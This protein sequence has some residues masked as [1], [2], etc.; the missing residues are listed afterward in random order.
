MIYT[1]YSYK[2]GVG[3]SMALANIAKYLYDRG[4]R[5]VMIDWDLEA[6]GLENFFCASEEQL[7]DV[8][9]QLGLIDMLEHYK[10]QFAQ[11]RSTPGV[12][13]STVMAQLKPQLLSVRSLLYPIH[14]PDPSAERSSAALW[15]LPAGWRATKSSGKSSRVDDR[16]AK[17]ASAVQSFDW[18]DFYTSFEGNAYFEWFREQLLP[19][20]PGGDSSAIPDRLGV[21]AVLIDSRTGVTEMG[22]ICTRQLADVVVCFC[23]PN[24]QNLEGVASMA[25]TFARDEIT[26]GRGRDLEVL[27]VPSRVDEQGA[28]T[29]EGAFHQRFNA[30]LKPPPTFQ[31]NGLDMYSLLLPYIAKYS[32]SEKLAV[33]VEASKLEKAYRRLAEHLVLFSEPDSM[34]R[35]WF[36][37][38]LQTMTRVTSPRVFLWS[39]EEDTTAAAAFAGQLA[40]I[41][42]A[43]LLDEAQSTLVWL[44]PASLNSPA[45]RR[46]VRLARQKG[47]CVYGVAPRPLAEP[48]LPRVLRKVRVFDLPAGMAGLRTELAKPCQAARV[49]SMAPVLPDF[50]DRPAELLLL[51]SAFLTPALDPVAASL[52]LSGAAGSGK[53]R[54][55]MRLCQ[56]EDIVDAFEDGI[57]WVALGATPDIAAALSGLHSALTGVEPQFSNLSSAVATELAG[58][59]CLVVFDDVWNASHLAAFPLPDTCARLILTRNPS[60]IPDARTINLDAMT[61]EQAQRTLALGLNLPFESPALEGLARR[62][63]R[64][65]LALSLARGLLAQ[66]VTRGQTPEAA[67]EFLSRTL[68]RKG[69]RA[70]GDLA[71]PLESAIRLTFDVAEAELT[72]AERELYADLAIFASDI[73]IPFDAISALWPQDALDT[74]HLLLRLD[75]LALLRV[76][77]Q[78]RI[79]HL[80][81]LL[82]SLLVGELKDVSALHARLLSTWADPRHPPHEF[83]WRWVIYHL[84]QAGRQNEARGLLLDFDWINAKSAATDLPALLADYDCFPDDVLLASVKQALREEGASVAAR[85]VRGMG[86]HLEPEAVILFQCARKWRFVHF[87]RQFRA[88][89]GCVRTLAA[90]SQWLISASDDE[91][92]AVWEEWTGS[93][94]RR[95]RGH[96]RPVNAVVL[97]DGDR[98]LSASN[99]GTLKL[100]DIDKGQL[101]HTF[102][103]HANWVL[104]LAKESGLHA[105]SGSID[106]T[107][108]EWDLSADVPARSLGTLP[109]W[110]TAI[111]PVRGDRRILCAAGDGLLHQWQLETGTETATLRGHT[112]WVSAL[113]VSPDG[114]YAVSGAFDKMLRL[115][116]LNGDRTT[117]AVLSGHT[118]AVNAVA[119]IPDLY[120]AV[121]VS[122]DKTL[123]VWD[124][125]TVQE[126]ASTSSD[127]EFVSCAVAPDNRTILCGDV[128]GEVYLF[129]MEA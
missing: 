120:R 27:I 118:A 64:W 69:V 114:R 23:A 68:D 125:S 129:E 51:R 86:Q 84:V 24:Y 8:R 90:N 3:R 75:K 4:V 1:F 66:Q 31:R 15:L 59:S 25:A 109:G 101:L 80:H 89:A 52:V 70:F 46:Q 85:L 58:K 67:A 44:T 48:H 32:Y 123:R 122:A 26:K 112:D 28:T 98:L 45:L 79:V 96:T 126:L 2:G 91:T 55:A 65:P 37:A 116:Q 113:A 76:D 14:A 39:S 20:P 104:S 82:R 30:R 71:P 60:L 41:G 6:P 38:E 29:E 128:S 72:P 108:L 21:D 19:A 9:S 92:I 127:R 56:D 102:A 62:L 97:F 47:I 5:V 87:V 16:F 12:E 33:G 119:L 10:R 83:A 40:S 121:S 36:S 88:H 57:L 17:Y 54:L 117:D 77:L 63:A 35:S 13:N 50:V 73:D 124:L 53:T 99:D 74:E 95:L 111:G 94:L 22:G 107:L 105:I 81:A 43:N 34:L 42:L 18:S 61:A 110:V 103:G 100:W 7:L 78:A 115:W 49:P 93:L 106:G 11:A